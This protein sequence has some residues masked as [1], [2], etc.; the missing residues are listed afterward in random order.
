MH[1]WIDLE[2]NA[3]LQQ[4]ANY[5][6]AGAYLVIALVALV[7]G[8]RSLLSVEIVP[9]TSSA[10]ADPAGAHSAAG[11]RVWLDNTEGVPSA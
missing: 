11:A 2:N 6:V 7:G 8:P 4:Y 9:E 10:L 5:G 3:L 1:R